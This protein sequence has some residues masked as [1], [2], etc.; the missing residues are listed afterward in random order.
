MLTEAALGVPALIV[1]RPV[2]VPLHGAPI[3][4]LRPA[5]CGVARVE[6]DHRLP[7]AKFFAAEAVVV[8]GIITRVGEGGVDPS[9]RG[10]LPHGRAEVGRI[11]ARPDAGH[12]ADDQMRVGMDDGGQ[13]R[14]GSLPMAGPVR[15]LHAEVGADVPRLKAGRIHGRQ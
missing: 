12:G 3:R 13:L 7:N 6:A 2:E 4:R 1:E 8:L 15:P 10:G 5:P 9:Q 11:L 14:L